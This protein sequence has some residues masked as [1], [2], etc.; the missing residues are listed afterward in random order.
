V[1]GQGL[2]AGKKGSIHM[3]G[4]Y[5]GTN[6]PGAALDPETNI[7]YVPSVHT[8]IIVQLVPPPEGSNV[9][10][11][12]RTWEP[13]VGPRELP[14]FKP[15]YGRLVAID[16]NKGEIKWTVANGDGPRDHPAIKDLKLQA[17]GNPGRVGPTV[18]K[19][20]VFMGEGYD[21]SRAGGAPYGGGKKFRAFDKSTGAVVWEMDLPGGQTAPAMTYRWQGKQY[22][23]LATGWTDTP[24]ELVALA[25]Q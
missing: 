17:L 16:L 4:T 20:L 14:M 11:V 24:G 5:G 21:T 10:L 6:W 8:P 25:L 19:S 1:P 18:T 22:I 13:V 7:L 23:V 9:N 12:R 3:P 2:G 15:P